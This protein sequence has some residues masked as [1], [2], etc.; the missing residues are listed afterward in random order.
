MLRKNSFTNFVFVQNSSM[1][2][3]AVME[4]IYEWFSAKPNT[5]SQKELVRPIIV[6]DWLNNFC[7]F[8]VCLKYD[9]NNN[10]TPFFVLKTVSLKPN[11]WLIQLKIIAKQLLLADCY[12]TQ[13][14][15]KNSIFELSN[16]QTPKL[17]DD[18]IDNP[19]INKINHI[20]CNLLRNNDSEL[21]FYFIKN[22]I[23]LAPFGMYVNRSTP[24]ISIYE[25][26]NYFFLLL[27][28]KSLA[29]FAVSTG[30]QVSNMYYIVGCNICHEQAQLRPCRLHIH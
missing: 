10:S 27:V 17:F 18:D 7:C 2:F 28:F 24:S 5:T 14:L 3:L 26:Q 8:C 20:T 23:S 9:H 22:D 12:F 1:I 25:H 30:T 6:I 4:T 13:F 21:Y 16:V 15:T 11:G 29:T 19:I